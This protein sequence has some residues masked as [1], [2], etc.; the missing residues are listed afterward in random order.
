MIDRKDVESEIRTA[1]S[2]L[3]GQVMSDD[4]RSQAKRAI[5]K[6]LRAHLRQPH[7]RVL[8]VIDSRDDGGVIRFRVQ[9]E[10]AP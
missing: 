9:T 10:A 3:V 6:I 1:L 2:P 5:E 8:G 7:V 4:L